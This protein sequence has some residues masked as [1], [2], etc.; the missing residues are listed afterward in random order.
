MIVT[1]V[2]HVSSDLA[3]LAI[4]VPMLIGTRLPLRRKLVLCGIFSLGAVNVL[5]AALNRYYNFTEPDDYVF[6]VW[7]CAEASTAVMVANMPFC[8]TLLQRVFKL[9]AWA[10]TSAPR[11]AAGGLSRRASAAIAMDVLRRRR[12]A[13]D[14]VEDTDG[15]IE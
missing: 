6:L 15:E 12:E 2:F 9:G 4:P 8:W 7:Y 14:R 11:A 5:V 13:W 1:S 3:M 10:V